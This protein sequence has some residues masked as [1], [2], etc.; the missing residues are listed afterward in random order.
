MARK[1]KEESLL[2]NNIYIHFDYYNLI[3]FLQ[4]VVPDL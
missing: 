2:G 1:K 3:I 4:N